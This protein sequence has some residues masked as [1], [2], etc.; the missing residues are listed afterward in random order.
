M[1]SKKKLIKENS[2]LGGIRKNQ[3]KS[4]LGGLAQFSYEHIIFL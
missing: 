1:E 3:V 2:R 4:H